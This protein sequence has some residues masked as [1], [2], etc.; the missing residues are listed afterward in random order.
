MGA[1]WRFYRSSLPLLSQ[2]P[3]LSINDFFVFKNTP[4][5]YKGFNNVNITCAFFITKEKTIIFFRR[6]WQEDEDLY[7]L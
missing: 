3:Y 4:A 7:I 5:V 1:V 6:G 2:V